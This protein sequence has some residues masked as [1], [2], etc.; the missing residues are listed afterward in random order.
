RS[1]GSGGLCIFSHCQKPPSLDC[2]IIFYFH[3][4]SVL[5]II[6]V[7]LVL[8]AHVMVLSIYSDVLTPEY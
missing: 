1:T 8:L 5:I 6:I 4:P 7:S 2:E 3:L